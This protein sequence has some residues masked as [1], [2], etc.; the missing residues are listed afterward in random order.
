MPSFAIAET[1]VTSCKGVTFIP[2]P[3]DIVASSNFLIELLL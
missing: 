2:C 3:K 1:A